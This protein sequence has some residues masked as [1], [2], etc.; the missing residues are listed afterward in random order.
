MTDDEL[1]RLKRQRD[2]YDSTLSRFP[3]NDYMRHSRDKLAKR[4]RD[5][6]ARRRQEEARRLREADQGRLF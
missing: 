5:E 2:W 6:E 3:S 1:E 4:I